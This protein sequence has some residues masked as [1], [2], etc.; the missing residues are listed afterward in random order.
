MDA[1][2][3]SQNAFSGIN[4]DLNQASAA[5]Q[6]LASSKQLSGEKSIKIPPTTL[7]I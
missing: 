6:R 3:I 5:S 7:L 4:K 2:L 1:G